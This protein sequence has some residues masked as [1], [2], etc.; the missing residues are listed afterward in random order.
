MPSSYSLS[1]LQFAAR[2]P[3][4]D[5]AKAMITGKTVSINFDVME[6]AEKRVE[7]AIRTDDIPTLESTDH[8]LLETDLLSYPIAKMIVS[9]MDARFVGKYIDAETRRA[10]RYLRESESEWQKLAKGFGISVKE[11]GMDIKAI[12][13]TSYL[14]FVPKVEGCSL[15]NQSVNDGF[16]TIDVKTFLLVLNEAVRTS[17]SMGLPIP[18]TSMPNDLKKDILDAA[19]RLE[20]QFKPKVQRIWQPSTS[21]EMAPCMKALM[22]KLRTGQNVPHV[23]RWALAIYLM[24]KGFDLD[25]ITNIFSGAPN[26]NEKTTK[27]QL[28]FIQ[29]KGYSVPLCVNL[30]SYGVCIAKCGTKS[31]LQYGSRFGSYKKRRSYRT[32]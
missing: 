22:E 30:D 17:V 9:C 16:V 5:A 3:F 4:T 8:K 12:D 10:T 2:Y 25:T 27:Y 31:P 20:E 23:G 1:E 18:Q 21:G 24:K 14:R 7:S 26:F 32:R 15:V 19:G 29:K 13:V 6:R 28:S 11:S